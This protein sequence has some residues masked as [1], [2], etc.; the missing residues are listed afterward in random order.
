M[1]TSSCQCCKKEDDSNLQ[2][3][4]E[5][6]NENNKDKTVSFRLGIEE[7]IENEANIIRIQSVFR[8]FMTRKKHSSELEQLTSNRVLTTLQQDFTTTMNIN[9]LPNLP[10]F[11]NAATRE[12]EQK[13]GPYIYINIPAA[14]GITLIEKGP[15]KLENG[16]VYFGQWR[17]TTQRDIIWGKGMQIW[18]DGA[19]YEGYWENG[20]ASGKG[21]LI[22][23][24]GD[25]YT[26]E[27]KNDKAEGYGEYRHK[28]GATYIGAWKDDKQHG[29][30]IETWPDGSKYE[31]FYEDTKKKGKGKFYWSDSSSYEGEFADNNINGLGTYIWT[32]GRKFTGRWKNNKMEGRGVF[33]WLDGRRYEGEYVDDKKQGQGT[34]YW[35]DGRCYAGEW[36]NGKQ[37]GKGKY[38]SADGKVR[39]AE[40]RNGKRVRW[41]DNL[42]DNK[43]L[44]S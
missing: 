32:D 33:T 44:K 43:V 4:E 15:I 30:G 28:D 3:R 14:P 2:I 18:P 6:K 22:H 40:W 19:K 27:W 24:D 10:D 29:Y 25:V 12:T 37:H 36:K 31:G 1:G 21:R 7:L 13:I 34:F 39:E 35:P 17:K 16:S 26:G 9:E 42:D 23:A 11:S 8:G 38:T 20:K 41:L 5:D